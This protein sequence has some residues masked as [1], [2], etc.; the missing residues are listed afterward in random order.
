MGFRFFRR[1]KIAPGLTL[2]LSKSG[3]SFSF[4]PRGMK[5]TVGPRG[6]RKTFGIPGT[7]VHYTTTS[8]WGKKQSAP[9]Q[10][11]VAAAPPSLD[12]GFFGNIFTPTDEKDLV[13]GL[14]QYLSGK[15]DDA[16]LTFRG[17]ASLVD[18]VFMAG[19]L[20]LGKDSFQ[21]AE[22]A[23]L[24]CQGPVSELGKAIRKYLQGFRLSLQITEYIDAPIDVDQR[25][26]ALSLAEA[27]QKQGKFADAIASIT[28][29]WDNDSSDV[30]ACLS[31]CE[32]VVKNPAATQADLNDIIRM[33]AS[34]ENDEPIH[35]NI[36][37]LRGAA[38]YRLQLADAAIQQLSAALRR[39]ADRPDALFYQIR[40]L[41][42][43]IYEQQGQTARARKDY[44]LVYAGDPGFKDVGKRLG[45]LP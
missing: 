37:Y 31:L 18:S 2:N 34:V 27:Y 7:G 25:G 40:Y 5:Y 15:T 44:E 32:L 10:A 3:P 26:L 12:L 39:K 21:E 9:S 20:A 6:T 1:V 38:M 24:K 22:A 19:F 45:Q 43:R 17:N 35:T 42:G 36:L 41:R 28:P 30:V 29:T 13:A 16:Y 23:F 4:G 11:A 8:G 33:T 14:K